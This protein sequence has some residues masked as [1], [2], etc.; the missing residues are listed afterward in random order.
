MPV[1]PLNQIRNPKSLNPMPEAVL[2]RRPRG[3]KVVATMTPGEPAGQMGSIVPHSAHAA[4]RSHDYHKRIRATHTGGRQ[5]SARIT[6]QL[7]PDSSVS[8]AVA[9]QGRRFPGLANG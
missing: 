1:K 5:S 9:T 8:E 2:N 3:Q 7:N 4:A 6:D